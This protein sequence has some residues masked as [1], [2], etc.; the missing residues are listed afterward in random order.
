MSI[1]WDGHMCSFLNSP[2]PT[3]PRTQV[4]DSEKFVMEAKTK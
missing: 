2:I 1:V 3:L 4:S